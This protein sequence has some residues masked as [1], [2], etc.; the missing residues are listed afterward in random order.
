MWQKK[1]RTFSPLKRR[2]KRGGKLSHKRG[3]DPNFPGKKRRRSSHL[4]GIERRSSAVCVYVRIQGKGGDEME[5]RNLASLLF[6]YAKPSSS[7]GFHAH[8]I[9]LLPPPAATANPQWIKRTRRLFF[10]KLYEFNT[11]F[12]SRFPLRRIE[13][14]GKNLSEAEN[15]HISSI[16]PPASRPWESPKIYFVFAFLRYWCLGK[17][18]N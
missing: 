1:E 10:G 13:A 14:V 5:G 3:T 9:F 12:C 15:L 6:F 11:V 18:A 16:L 17:R 4:F 8:T 7:S 2:E